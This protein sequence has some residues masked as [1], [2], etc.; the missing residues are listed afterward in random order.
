MWNN[1]C[2]E[3]RMSVEII[4]NLTNV[5][6]NALLGLSEYYLAREVYKSV[7]NASCVFNIF[8]MEIK[9][10]DPTKTKDLYLEYAKYAEENHR[11]ELAIRCF[12]EAYSRCET[13]N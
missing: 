4:F 2:A 6:G 7:N 1:V 11:R 3:V 10:L 5:L 12:Q 13:Y 8:E 9:T